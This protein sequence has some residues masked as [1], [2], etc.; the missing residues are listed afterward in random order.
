MAAVV[1]GG[2]SAVAFGGPIVKNK[3]FF[4]AVWDMLF[5]RQR[6]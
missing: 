4:Y 1:A 2:V 5:N 3:T 6:A